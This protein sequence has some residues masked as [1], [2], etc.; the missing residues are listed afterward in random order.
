MPLALSA[1]I[2]RLARRV[3]DNDV[4]RLATLLAAAAFFADWASKSWALDHL[5]GS[6]MPLG[7]LTLGVARNEAF[8]FSAGYGQ[9]SPWLVVCA[10]LAA[11]IIIV[12]LCRRIAGL[13]DRRNACGVALVL[14]GGFGNAADLVFRGGA[15]VD[16]IGAG[17]F[18][19]DWAG[20]LIQ[21]H[22]VFNAADIFILMGIGL[23]APLIQRLGKAAQRRLAAWESRVLARA[24]S[25]SSSSAP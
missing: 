1:T 6:T 24:T 10:R 21:L 25:S 4:L 23:L 22:V 15:V 13:L 14:A 9:V 11:L 12:L 19:F 3:R 17:P 8:A 16:F 20:E 5:E 7:A 2:P 18:V